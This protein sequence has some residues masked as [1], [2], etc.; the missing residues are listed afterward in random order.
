MFLG[1]DLG[2][3]NIK[4]LLVGEGG[5]VLARASEPVGLIHT[6]EAGVEQ[7][8]EEIWA[9][10]LSA[11]G[12]IGARRKRNRVEAIGVSSQGGALQ[13]LSPGGQPMAN[14]ISWLDGRGRADDE[15][16]TRELGGDWFA[17]RIGHARSA[18]SIGQLL[19]FRREAPEAFDGGFRIRFVGDVI[20]SRLCGRAAHDA[21]SLSI[22][23]LFNPWLHRADPDVLGRLGVREEQLPALLSPREAAGGLLGP[24]AQAT[25]LPAGIPV[26]AAVHDQYASALGVGAVAPGDVMFGAGTAWVLLAAMER[27]AAPPAEGAF[28]CSHLVEGLYGQMLSLGN[29]GSAV[30]LALHLTGLRPKGGDVDAILSGIPPGSDGLR[31]WPFLVPYGG[32][33]LAA[34]TSARLLGLRLDHRPAHVVRAAIEGLALEL[35]RYLGFLDRAGAQVHRLAMCG[36]AARSGLTPQIVANAAGLPVDCAAE[37]DTSALGAAVLARGLVEP[38]A[39][40]GELSR[41]AGKTLRSFEPDGDAGLYRDMLSEYLAALPKAR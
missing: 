9:A 38:M 31:F 21:T 23:M 18:L 13:L 37:T 27:L 41:G 15:A 8:I 5:R 20:V 7:D 12:W 32:V 40:L 28:V 1:L 6:G 2:T 16:L 22:A 30:D 34:A 33:G 35:A 4:A 36:G 19:R 17:H 25:G 14:V 11:L 3:T 39:P 24:V 10:T 26:S 29:G